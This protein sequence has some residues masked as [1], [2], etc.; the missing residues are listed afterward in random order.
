MSTKMLPSVQ[1]SESLRQLA[2]RTQPITPSPILCFDNDGGR[3][4]IDS[5][6][7]VVTVAGA[8]NREAD[9]ASRSITVR[10]TSSDG[11]YTDQVFSIAINDVDEFDV[12][13][14][15]D[16]NAT[17]NNVNEN[18]TLVPL[19]ESLPQ[20]AMRTQPTTASLT[21][22]LT[23]TVVALPSTAPRA[24]LRLREPS[25]EKPMGL[26]APSLCEPP[27]ADG[28]YTDQIFSIGIN[29]VDEFDVGTVTDTNA[30]SNNVNEN[31]S[32]GTVVGI[33]ALQ[34]AMQ[35]PLT[36]PSPT[37][38]LTMTVEASP[39]T[40]PRVSLRLPE[41]LTEKPMGPRAPSLYEPL[42]PTDL[43]PI[44]FSRSPSTTSMNLTSDRSPTPMPP[45]TMSMKMQ[46]L[47]L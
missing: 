27:Q 44:K 13:S 22:C 37:L 26:L 29:D 2:M 38:C 45:A 47:E 30:T 43:I 40:A 32:V 33:T 39:S 7:G 12:G 9:G 19:L 20:P 8:I 18:A 23:M 41:P 46:A 24:S 25:T 1:S 28:S 42:Q 36:T 31:A 6:T 14:V 35:T 15:T 10:A 21:L 4:A 34:P 17:S 3:F 11:S 5:T 16:T